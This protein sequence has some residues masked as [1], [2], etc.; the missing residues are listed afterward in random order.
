MNGPRLPSASL[1]STPRPLIAI[2]APAC[3]RWNDSRVCS[4]SALKMSSIWVVSRTWAAS[5]W[6]PSGIGS[7][8]DAWASVAPP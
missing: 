5:R 2:A 3:Q 4:S 8:A 6:P 1:R 7:A